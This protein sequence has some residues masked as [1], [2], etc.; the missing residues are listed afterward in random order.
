MKAEGIAYCSASG[1]LQAGN[2]QRANQWNTLK[3]K[4]E[5]LKILSHGKAC[6]PAR[7]EESGKSVDQGY[8]TVCRKPRMLCENR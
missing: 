5:E 2:S 3:T 1:G 7:S 4:A 6:Q 8:N